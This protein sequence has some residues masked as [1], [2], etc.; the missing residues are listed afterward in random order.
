[1]LDYFPRKIYLIEMMMMICSFYFQSY[2]FLVFRARLQTLRCRLDE[3][4]ALNIDLRI[5]WLFRRLKHIDMRLNVKVT[6][7]IFIM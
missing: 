4:R 3:V 7:K 1:M 6:G 5:R 2:L